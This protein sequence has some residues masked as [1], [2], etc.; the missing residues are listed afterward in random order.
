M[1]LKKIWK[2]KWFFR[3]FIQTLYFN[4]HYLPFNQAIHLPIVLYKPTLLKMKGKIIL[5]TESKIKFGM[6]ELGAFHCSLYPNSGIVFENHGGT[7]VFHGNCIIGN[8]SAI[9]IGTNG[10]LDIG[11]DFRVNATFRCV[12]YNK[13]HF[14]T[15]T[16]FG[17]DCIVMDTDLH[18]LTK[19]A[20]GYTKGFGEIFIGDHNWIGTKSVVLKRTKTPDFCTFAAT[21]LLNAEYNIPKYSIAGPNLYIE[22]KIEGLWRNVD[23]DVID[24]SL[25]KS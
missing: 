19:T 10:F 12:C 6:I 15:K 9:S 8:S 25:T 23:D 14:G 17:W 13:I 18:K 22:K 5:Q 2:K 11:H 21:S 24:Y 4:F 7:I 20:G 16:R 1:L 3:N